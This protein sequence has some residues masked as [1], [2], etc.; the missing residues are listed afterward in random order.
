[1][2]LWDK[3]H[4]FFSLNMMYWDLFLGELQIRLG[5]IWLFCS[6]SSLLVRAPLEIKLQ[7]F[8]SLL[9]LGGSEPYLCQLQKDCKKV[10]APQ[11]SQS[12]AWNY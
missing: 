3:K 1:M 7:S 10:V 8:R 2:E 12:C 9:A 5:V 11:R 6:S 4:L